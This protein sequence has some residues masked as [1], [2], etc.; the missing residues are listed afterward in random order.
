MKL[1]RRLAIALVTVLLTQAF[2]PVALAHPLGNFTINQF[3]GLRVGPGSATVEYILDMAEI[4]AFQEIAFLDVD[5]DNV[6]DPD[7]VARYHAT[8]CEALRGDLD[9]RLAGRALNLKL[10]SSSVEFPTGAGGLLTLR[11]TC[12]FRAAWSPADGPQTVS[13]SSRA[14]ADRLGWREIV[15]DADGV[16]LEGDFAR[17]SVSRKLTAYPDDLLA[18]PPDQRQVDFTI[19]ALSGNAAETEVQSA[20]TP[21]AAAQ[22]DALTRLITLPELTLP[23]LLIALGIAFVWGAM[24]AMTPGHGKTVVGAYLVGSRGTAKHALYLGLATTVTHTAGVF[25]LGLATLFAS[26][27]IL[28]ERLF[29]WLSL[30]SGLLVVGIGVSLFQSRVRGLRKAERAAHA[31][32]HH[33]HGHSH[34]HDHDHAH[35]HDHGHTHSHL[36]PGADG[37]RVT[38]RGLL[39]LGVSGGLLPCPSALWCC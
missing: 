23:T 29:P 13:F 16:T 7:R 12:Q 36:P 25:A 6:P 5:Q 24:H 9:L 35:A 4:P 8:E 27:F 26:E 2:V 19:A 17:E 15:V 28:P 34:A 37:A 14:Y 10:E 22:D 38:W 39:A 31:H 21:A 1:P 30:A 3:A 32:D 18:S 33:D 11:L 20:V